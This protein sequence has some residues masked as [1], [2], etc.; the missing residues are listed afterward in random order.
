MS[1]PIGANIP[2]AE[3]PI[4][5]CR[6]GSASP[7]DS[8]FL[9][10]TARIM[11]SVRW[12]R[13]LL[14]EN[15]DPDAPEAYMKIGDVFALNDQGEL[16]STGHVTIKGSGGARVSLTPNQRLGQGVVLA[17]YSVPWILQ[18]LDTEFPEGWS[19]P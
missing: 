13:I 3:R 17:G 12:I 16:V 1:L 4:T 5:D 11:S 6:T 15:S 8:L 9:A 7:A 2:G 18:N 14:A 10:P 19:S